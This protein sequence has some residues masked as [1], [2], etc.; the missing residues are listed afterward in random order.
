[1]KNLL[2]FVLVYLM[3]IGFPLYAVSVSPADTGQETLVKKDI[4]GKHLL[5][6]QWISWERFGS[7]MLTPED[8]VLGKYQCKGSQYNEDKSDW[9]V[10][11]GTITVQDARHLVFEGVIKTRVS[12]IA[13]GEEQTRKGRFDF[14]ASGKRKYWRLQQMDNPGDVCVDYIDIYF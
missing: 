14:V 11:E 9:L 4:R 3:S 2:F 6:L 12:Y 1:M 13:G 5:S 8:G 10:L 7:V